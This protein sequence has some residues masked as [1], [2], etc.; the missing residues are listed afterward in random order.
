[1]IGVLGLTLLGGGLWYASLD[2]ETR[3]L[4][5]TMPT[6]ADVLMWSQRQRDAGFRGL[7][8]IPRLI[9]FS[10]IAPSAAPRQLAARRRRPAAGGA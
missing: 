9:P 10:E 5:A 2:R 7:D 8:R 3:G 1:M 4:L 6:D